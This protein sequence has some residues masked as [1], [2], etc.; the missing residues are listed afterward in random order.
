MEKYI[1][2]W[3]ETLKEPYRSQALHNYDKSKWSGR[4]EKTSA[5][6][7]A[8]FRA[9]DWKSSSEED[10]YWRKIHE[11]I[12]HN[13]ESKYIQES[14]PV[15]VNN[16]QIKTITMSEKTEVALIDAGVPQVL[17]LLNDKIASLKHIEETVYKTTGN[18]E[19]FGDL[20]KETKLEN[21]IRAY[22]SVF[23]REKHYN[24]AA[25]DLGLKRY[26]AFS[27]SGG[28]TKQWKHDIELRINIITHKESLD[29]L[30]GYKEK[31]SKFM[32][33]AEQKAILIQEMTEFFGK[34]K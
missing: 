12:K 2:E 23:L 19:G 32:S 21:L 3:L 28:N 17:Q 9:F 20:T 16:Y 8:L 29:K 26:P 27:I 25:A 22:S 11:D 5:L 13:S 31:M 14:K 34:G 30:N 6:S 1:K 18:L 10:Q 33:E 4:L 24:E 7:K 15:I